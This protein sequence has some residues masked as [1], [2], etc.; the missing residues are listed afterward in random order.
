VIFNADNAEHLPERIKMMQAWADYLDA[1]R[2]G[3][4]VISI[5]QRL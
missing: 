3:A 5:N 4:N 2:D 1:L